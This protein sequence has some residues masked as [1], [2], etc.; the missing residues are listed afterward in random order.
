MFSF[1][2]TCH[3]D[4]GG[5]VICD[6]C[7][8]GYAGDKCERY[9]NQKNGNNHKDFDSQTDQIRIGCVCYEVID[10]LLDYFYNSLCDCNMI[11]YCI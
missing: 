2:P 3:L 5:K 7:P 11:S 1:S 8:P 9:G 4:N 10:L 6:Q